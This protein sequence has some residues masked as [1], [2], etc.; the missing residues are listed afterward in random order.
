[1]A[2]RLSAPSAH[3]DRV[4]EA[5]KLLLGNELHYG[6]FRTGDEDLPTATGELTR[7]MEEGAQLTAGCTVLDVGCGTG[8]PACRLAREY[9]AHVTGITTSSFGVA[10]A[11]ARAAEAGLSEL[12][13]FEERDGM[14]N[15]FPD[16]SFDRVWVLESSHLMRDRDRVLSEG[17][18]VLKPGGR[19]ALCDIILRR[20]M[21]FM[22]V[23]RLRRE[24]GVLRDVFGDARMEPLAEYRR[25]AEAAGLEVDQETDL[26]EATRPTFD[27]W[28]ANAHA[29]RDEVVA[30]IG[31][32]DWALFVESCDV[33]DTFW[34]DGTLGYGLLTARK[35]G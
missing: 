2:E 1:M 30:L 10:A 20:P 7:L 11:R 34:G 27:R 15:G 31:E 9:G 18:R 8:A 25:L 33:L 23:R 6:V 28:R 5:W 19:L 17:S 16:A 35:P 26:T 13:A 12:T 4:T 3:Y 24:L 32:E 29:H 21:D 14:D 22:E